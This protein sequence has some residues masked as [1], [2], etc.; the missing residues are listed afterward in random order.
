MP[1][2]TM[3]H[4]YKSHKMY[5]ISDHNTKAKHF[6]EK[7]KRKKN[8]Q[9]NHYET[10][11]LQMPLSSFCAGHLLMAMGCLLNSVVIPSDTLQK[12]LVFTL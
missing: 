2:D 10:S 3:A 9:T 6:R 7:E 12:N 5:N 1:I 4:F 11:N 8:A